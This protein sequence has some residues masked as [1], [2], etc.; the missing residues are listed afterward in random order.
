M[1]PPGARLSERAA[2]CTTRLARLCRDDRGATAL[3]YS[4]IAVFIAA[5]IVAV[6]TVLGG[7][8]SVDFSSV[9]GKF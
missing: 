6:V 2:S 3:E 5:L 4:L 8:V 1:R 9:I 7:Q